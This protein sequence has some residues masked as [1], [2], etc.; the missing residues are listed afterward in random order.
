V[1]DAAAEAEVHRRFGTQGA[2]LVVDFTGMVKRT[3]ARGIVYA[4]GRARQA[5][6]AMALG[7][8]RV[9]RVADTI[10]ML[11]SD[12]VAA[13]RDALDAHRRL[14]DAMHTSD[15]PIQA[16]IGLGFGPMLVIPAQ[17]CFGAEV[18]RAFVL[19]EDVARGG[20]TLVTPAF[21]AALGGLPEGVGAFAAPADRVEE[22]GFSFHVVGDYR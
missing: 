20:E 14:H 8:T 11:Y 22:A 7:G 13:L 17:D 18:N 3:D 1:E 15:D 12:P 19:G 2:V 6:H 21:L 4:L 9:K 5:D 16:C 10:F